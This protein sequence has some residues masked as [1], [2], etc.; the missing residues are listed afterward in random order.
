MAGSANAARQDELGLKT[1]KIKKTTSS[2]PRR[3]L[4]K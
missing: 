1:A 4:G 3:P 2:S